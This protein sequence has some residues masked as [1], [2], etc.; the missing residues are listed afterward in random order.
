MVKLLENQLKEKRDRIAVYVMSWGVHYYDHIKLKKLHDI[1]NKTTSFIIK[2]TNSLWWPCFIIV[3][4][5][6][7]YS[8]LFG[9]MFI[10]TKML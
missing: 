7:H 1:I 3:D 4:T 2:R 9:H 10:Y 6:N 8:P 5:L